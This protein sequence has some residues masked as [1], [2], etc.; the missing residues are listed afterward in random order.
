MLKKWILSFSV[1]VTLVLSLTLVHPV[2][3]QEQLGS[4]EAT[5]PSSLLTAEIETIDE[6]L[7]SPEATESGDDST[8]SAT[9]ASP[10]AEKVQKVEEETKKD[11]TEP[12]PEQ[13]SK[14]A[15][16]MEE[17]PPGKLNWNNF[18]QHAI[19]YAVK[20]G[21][22]ANIL[23][24][25]LLFPLIASFIAASRHIIGLRGFGLYIPAVLAVA[26]VSTGIFEGLIIFLAIT[27]TAL[28]AKKIIQRFDMSYLPRTALL[29]WT[30][31]LGIFGLLL[32]APILNLVSLMKG[33]VFPILILVLLSE[34]F[35]DAQARTKQSEAI[36]LAIETIGLAFISGL[37]LQSESMQKFALTEPELLILLTA[38]LNFVIGKFAGLRVTEL[39]RFRPIIEEEE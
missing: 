26:L 23:V 28:L 12:T 27:I 1:F 3:S 10:S 21:M 24:L 34:N 4:S 20:Q 32:L 19:H 37:L 35:L 36:A 5:A 15:K 13:K 22:P 18:V 29:L 7:D 30:I 8:P 2:F 14:L 33:N 16:F 31:S 39:L 11:I 38:G 6:L 25:V 17:N 9:L